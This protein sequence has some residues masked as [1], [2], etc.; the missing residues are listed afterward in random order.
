[1]NQ[2]YLSLLTQT[3]NDQALSETTLED[4]QKK[5]EEAQN[6]ELNTRTKYMVFLFVSLM[7]IDRISSIWFRISPASYLCLSLTPESLWRM[8]IFLSTMILCQST[9]RSM[10]LYNYDRYHSLASER[11]HYKEISDSQGSELHDK[12]L[13]INTLTEQNNQ[14]ESQV[15]DL[16]VLSLMMFPFI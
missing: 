5:L 15:N 12:L 4:L 7:I 13:T 9:L 14:Y 16:K 3:Q 2:K 10:W 1:M 11:D 6:N 8:K